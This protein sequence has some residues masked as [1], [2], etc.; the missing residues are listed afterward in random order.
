MQNKFLGLRTVIFRVPDLEKAKN[1]YADV[2]GFAPY[3][4]EVFYVG[5]EVSGYELGL[6]PEEG[7]SAKGESITVYW[8]V[9][10]V[11]ETYKMLIEKGAKEDEKPNEVGSG[12]IVASVRDPWENILGII[13]NP[14][15]KLS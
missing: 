3:F 10:N 2:L 9:E 15:F 1:W 13:Y 5:F 4:D 7:K 8:G 6:I 14:H 12:I 11:K